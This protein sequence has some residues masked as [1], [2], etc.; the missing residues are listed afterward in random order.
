MGHILGYFQIKFQNDEVAKFCI[1]VLTL[2]EGMNFWSP[3]LHGDV[4]QS[5][6]NLKM[7]LFFN[8]ESPNLKNSQ[9]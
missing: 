4:P 9:I 8:L 1:K 7:V 3:K 5:F 2:P 6:L